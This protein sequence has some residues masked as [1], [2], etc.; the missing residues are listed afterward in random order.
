MIGITPETQVTFD[1]HRMRRM[2]LAFKN[3]RRQKGC[4]KPAIDLMAAGEIN[5]D[6]MLTHHYP[7]DKIQDAFELV[8][9][10]REGVVKAMVEIPG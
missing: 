9:G 3:V 5:A 7:F 8:A 4:M 10:Y 1:A 6:P 2:E